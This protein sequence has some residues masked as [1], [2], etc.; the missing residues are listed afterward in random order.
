MYKCYDENWKEDTL[1]YCTYVLINN[2]EEFINDCRKEEIITDGL[3]NSYGEAEFKCPFV[4]KMTDDEE[5][6]YLSPNDYPTWLT[7][8]IV[9]SESESATHES[10]NTNAKLYNLY[11]IFKSGITLQTNTEPITF[12][13]ITEAIEVLQKPSIFGKQIAEFKIE[14]L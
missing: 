1:G 5:W 13:D 10:T 2:Y 11:V 6:E 9:K 8:E 12:E 7:T 4:V 3:Y 14:V